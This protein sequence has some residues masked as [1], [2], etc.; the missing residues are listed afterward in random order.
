MLVVA[1]TSA[2]LALT[3]CDGLR[4][5]DPLFRD[6]RVPRAVFRECVVPD[7]PAAKR[8]ADYWVDKIADVDLDNP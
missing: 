8:L 2:L 3:A 1:D 6:I 5:L 4:L 7:K